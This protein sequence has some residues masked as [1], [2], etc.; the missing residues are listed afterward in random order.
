A[1]GVRLSWPETPSTGGEIR[2]RVL[3]QWDR[4]PRDAAD[5][6]VIA[7]AGT[8]ARDPDPPVN[9][10][11]F[12]AVVAQRGDATAP[13]VVTGPIRVRPE[14]AD[15]RL[16]GGD[17]VVSGRWRCPPAAA[18]VL[19]TRDTIGAEGGDSARTAEPEPVRAE[20]TGFRDTVDN[21]TTYHY[22]IAAVYLDE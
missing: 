9:V 10:P 15:V 16:I 19:V 7:S 6:E 2:Y 5:G 8:T 12:Y 3:R 1:R 18:R 13:P 22:R 21:G 20:R 14:P 4:P 11:L 17:G